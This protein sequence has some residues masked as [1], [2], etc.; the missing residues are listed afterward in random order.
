M[1]GRRTMH[2]YEVPEAD[3][4]EQAQ[5]VGDGDAVFADDET[6]AD[7]AL[8]PSVS[9]LAADVPEADALEQAQPAGGADG[10][11]WYDDRS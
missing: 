6:Y 11:D 3:A 1:T 10:D 9:E 4:L 7:D 8:L 2:D 5:S